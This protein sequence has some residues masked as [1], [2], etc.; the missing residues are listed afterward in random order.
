MGSVHVASLFSINSVNFV[1]SFIL[2]PLKES[3]SLS[4]IISPWLLV[5]NTPKE[6]SPIPLLYSLN[7]LESLDVIPELNGS[8]IF[9]KY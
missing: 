5:I 7:R 3:S 8:S 1:S 4:S 2:I 9:A 6:P